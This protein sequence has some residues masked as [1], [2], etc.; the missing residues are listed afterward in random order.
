MEKD[1]STEDRILAA[2]RS[3][4]QQKGLAGARMQEIANEAGI[5]KA[6]L[7]YYFR[8]KDKL[9]ER[10][11]EE[12]IGKFLPELFG[13][14]EDEGNILEKI[15]RFVHRYISFVAENPFVPSLIL[16]ELTINP[17]KAGMIRK[18]GFKPP[19]DKMM[20]EVMIGVQAGLIR[21]VHP[22]DLILNIISMCVFPVLARNMI[23]GIMLIDDLTYQEMIETRKK[24]VADFVIQSLRP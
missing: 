22:M 18:M 23:Q 3:I 21:P 20:M 6:L 17:E 15:E 1:L 14:W 10:I 12:A 4:F 5:N 7:H 11:L 8:S 24:S 2:A 16:Q 19:K 13:V 9:F